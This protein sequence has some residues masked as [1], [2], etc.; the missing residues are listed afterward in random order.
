MVNR[1]KFD[2][3][4]YNPFAQSRTEYPCHI[5]TAED[6]GFYGNSRNQRNDTYCSNV[7]RH[8]D[9]T[10]E[11][12]R[13]F[14]HACSM[15]P[16]D[17]T[18]TSC[19]YCINEGEEFAASYNYGEDRC[20][21]HEPRRHYFPTAACCSEPSC[22]V[23][24][25]GPISFLNNTRYTRNAYGEVSRENYCEFCFKNGETAVIYKSHQLRNP[26]GS[27]AC[28]LLKEYACC[29]CGIMDEGEAWN[30]GFSSPSFGH[31]PKK[32]FTC[33]FCT[34][35]GKD[36]CDGGPSIRSHKYGGGCIRTPY[37]RIPAPFHARR[38]HVNPYAYLDMLNYS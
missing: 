34:P 21:S 29:T 7:G 18:H 14:K 37:E 33:L 36:F 22:S 30:Y 38:S 10:S 13:D 6:Q 12:L 19:K 17:F 11:V 28:P 24:D 1:R 23:N 8:H 35:N 5:H 15:C 25:E 3:A 4:L 26:S 16:G 32:K 2:R 27:I 9:R 20:S 31:N